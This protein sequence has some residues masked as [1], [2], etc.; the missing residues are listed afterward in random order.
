MARGI[1]IAPEV[2][3]ALASGEAVVA[4][5]TAAVTHGL[6]REPLA[7]LPPYL[8]DV[9]TPAAVRACFAGGVAANRALGHALAAAVRA[10]GAVPATVGMLGGE[11]VIGLTSDQLDE[12]AECRD[13]RKLSAREIPLSAARGESGGTT[14]A[15]TLLACARAEPAPIRVFATGGIGGVHRGFAERPDVSADL[16]AIRGT[17]TLV[18]TAGAKSILDLPATVEVLDTL[19]VPLVGL[20]TPYFPRFLSAG[21]PELRVNIEARDEHDAARLFESHLAM[22]GDCGM[23]LCVP[24]LARF[25]L[26]PAIMESAIRAGLEECSRIGAHGPD[27]TPVLLAALAQA[28]GGASL[29]TNLAVLI[30]NARIGARVAR[31][32]CD[33]TAPAKPV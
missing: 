18:V 22:R 31:A 21:S 32:H 23:L 14:V 28:T 29:A 25:A 10:E 15:G 20:R 5:E 2:R 9:D 33:L 8:V 19:G 16:N 13:A 12:L 4:L 27:V 24:P 30:H 26:E 3:D 17:P 6:P 7:S 11:L 1:R